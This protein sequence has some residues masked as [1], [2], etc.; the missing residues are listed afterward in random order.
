MILARKN[1]VQDYELVEID[2]IEYLQFSLKDVFSAAFQQAGRLARLNQ[3]LDVNKTNHPNVK[4]YFYDI[5]GPK[6]VFGNIWIIGKRHVVLQ[7]GG[8]IPIR[9][10]ESIEVVLQR[11]EG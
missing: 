11:G 9:A 3:C 4:I 1:N 2:K 8:L 7:N 6:V 5:E 10:I